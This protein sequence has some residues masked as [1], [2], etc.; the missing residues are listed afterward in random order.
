MNSA[1]SRRRCA[2]VAA[3]AA[4][5]IAASLVLAAPAGARVVDAPIAYSS[6]DATLAITPIGTYETG[7]FDASA[8]EIVAFHGTRLYVVNAQAGVVDVL[9]ASNPAAPTK[10]YTIAGE[11]VA[12]SITVRADGLG[13]VAFE[14]PTKTEPGSILFF[15]ADAPEPVVLG[16]VTVGAL[17]DNVEISPDGTYAVVA[18]EGEP[19]DDFAIDPE[20]S[21]SV[22]A[23]PATKAAPAQS[24]VRTADFH[25]FEIGGSKTL[26]SAVRVFGPTPHGDDLPVSR[27]LEPEYIAVDGG[28]A[29]AA[30]Q[31]ANAVAVIDLAS[32]TVT[33]IWPLGFKD[34][35]VAGNGI[36][37]SDRDPQG[38]STFNVRTFENLFG[39][40]NP[41][42]IVAYQA[43]GQTFLVTANEGDV[44]EWGDYVEAT[45]AK[46][47]AKNGYGPVSAQLKALLG[48]GDLGRLNVSIEDGF[49]EETG[50]YEALYTYGGRSFSIWTTEGTQV[51]DSGD[52]FENITYV[53]NPAYFNS[54]HS[55]ANFEGRSDDKGPEPE[56][57]AIG[58]VGGRTY[59][60]IGLERVGGVMVFDIT[61]PA[62]AAFVTYVDNRDFTVDQTTSAAGD[63]GPE[64]LEFISG[65]ASPTGLPLLAVGNEVSGT[66]TLFSL[67]DLTPDTARPVV[68]L[69]DTGGNVFEGNAVTLTL[70]A[71]D[72]RALTAVVGTIT[73]D[74]EV[75]KHTQLKVDGAA[76][77][78]HTI[79]LSSVVKG[80]LPVGDYVLTFSA[81]DAARNQSEPQDFAF[82]IVDTTR[83]E[84]VLVTPTAAAVKKLKIQID[85]T[86]AQGLQ[87]V[88]ANVYRDGKLVTS[89]QKDAKGKTSATHKATVELADGT[90]QVKYNAQ[91]LSG[92]VS[93]T[94]TYTVTVDSTRPTITVKDGA[95]YT[96]EARRGY[97]LVS[98]KLYDAGKVARLTLNGVEKDLTDNA[99]SD[100]NFVKPGKFGA[101]AGANVLVV[102]DVAGNAQ[103]LSF[104]L[105]G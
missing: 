102:Y 21:V 1:F 20:G 48:D 18:N 33:D 8:A 13:V 69:G 83:P 3:V 81:R 74:G 24:A 99:W 35:G 30:L 14:N 86:D 52:Q 64:G 53:A 15:D 36:D 57:L 88:V 94:G 45:R 63:L 87:R 7:V 34:H 31:E 79:D 73:R 85:A 22:I 17:P 41:D 58:A 51:F 59:A 19:D 98:F 90:Y 27:N 54:N 40:Y 4:V 10:L 32:A 23:L 68:A 100:L 97:E 95:T 28:T 62:G 49:N 6:D 76:R 2:T 105:A 9:D 56:N 101:V 38:A 96:R 46:D 104:R 91:D 25:E 72:D 37:P 84:V 75:V 11:G 93:K 103:R 77:A 29:Y 26:D 50:Q 47:I 44:R 89:T 61:D 55:E 71:S 66:T 60:F 65:A 70:N 67:T 5:S 80:G 42:G 16:S 78:T 43:G 12:N 39:I 82:S 92:N